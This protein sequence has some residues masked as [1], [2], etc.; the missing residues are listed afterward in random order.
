M[1]MSRRTILKAGAGT[2]LRARRSPPGC[3]AEESRG[4]DADPRRH[5]G[6]SGP[7]MTAAR[8]RAR[9]GRSR[10]STAASAMPDGVENVET[11][12]G[13]RRGQ[14]DSLKGTQV[15]RRRRQHRLHPEVHEDVG[16][17]ARAEHGLLPLHL[18]HLGLRE[19]REAQRHRLADRRAREQGPGRDHERDL[20]ADEGALRA[21]TCATPTAS[22]PRSCARATSWGR[23]IRL[24]ASPTGPCA[25]RR[26]ATWPCRERLPIPSRSW[27]CAT[28][29]LSPMGLRSI[30]A[31]T[32]FQ[33][34]HA[35]RR[36]HHGQPHGHEP[37]GD[38]R[39]H[40][41]SRGSTRISSPPR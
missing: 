35:A 22:A 24:I 38:G 28:S 37:Q 23:S 11:L 29:L 3:A 2:A 14:L 20:R 5:A 40:R 9:G 33:R 36:D 8:A 19:L 4:H 15:G 41:S 27:T 13:D 16:G 12:N 32:V 26:A 10:T 25:L 6:S 18:E 39:G 31:W 30:G 7:H 1:K 17:P 21:D 34:R